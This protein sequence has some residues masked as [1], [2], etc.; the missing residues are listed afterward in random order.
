MNKRGFTLIELLS[1]V[2]ILAIISLIA[3]PQ[4]SKI[5][6][7]TKKDTAYKSALSLIESADLY[8]THNT[9]T[10]YSDDGI[11]FVCDGEKCSNSSNEQLSTKGKT[12]SK[13]E[14]QLFQNGDIQLNYVLLNDG[15][16]AYGT[17][18]NLKVKKMKC[19]IFGEPGLYDENNKLIISWDDLVNDYQLSADAFYNSK[20]YVFDKDV[21]DYITIDSD[22]E[23]K[24]HSLSEIIFNH[25][26]FKRAVKLVVGSEVKRISSGALANLVNIKEI[27]LPDELTYIDQFAF[28]RCKKLEKI[29]I[30]ESVNHIGV[31][32]FGDCD[33]LKSL[34]IPKNVS[35][36]ESIS[37]SS[38]I[39]VTISEDNKYYNDLNSGYIVRKS[40]DALIYLGKNT[41]IPN[42]IKVIE[43]C[44]IGSYF[45]EDNLVIPAGVTTIN[46]TAIFLARFKHLFISKTVS[47]IDT[48]VLN[49]DTVLTIEID[50][51]NQKYSDKNS[52]VIYEL[53]TDKILDACIS[54]TIP[55]GTKIIDLDVLGEIAGDGK[56]KYAKDIIIP[57]SV[58]EIIETKNGYFNM[59][60]NRDEGARLVFEKTSGWYKASTKNA[61]SGESIEISNMTYNR[62]TDFFIGL[63]VNRIKR[64]TSS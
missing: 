5:V 26:E 9:K 63:N 21:Y 14:I 43:E 47:S 36:L 50:D 49:S 58:E 22:T 38:I 10:V 20:S 53:N 13:G 61:T 44:S 11:V 41:T 52:N 46:G 32:A 25:P 37:W 18:D 2:A 6:Q 15:Y 51:D 27:V 34:Y 62:F 16:C 17:K 64:N 56:S 19:E 40:D 39:D 3:I 33:K 24:N 8:F 55:A 31:N 45:Q 29:N 57:S 35:Y 48:N 28:E 12:P 54:S 42:S 7:N 59:F 1:V 4:I 30:P 23:G 60:E